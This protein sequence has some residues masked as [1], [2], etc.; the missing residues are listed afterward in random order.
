MSIRLTFLF[1]TCVL[2]LAG[3]AFSGDKDG[4][5]GGKAEPAQHKH[6]SSTAEICSF[7]KKAHTKLSAQYAEFESKTLDSHWTWSDDSVSQLGSALA[8]LLRR[9]AEDIQQS[10]SES[11][12]GPVA[13]QVKDLAEQDVHLAEKIE[14][15]T[16][17][18]SIETS[19]RLVDATV[20]S[21]K[22]ICAIH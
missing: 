5:T 4:A 18:G 14:G 8:P 15:R 21:V 11:A 19:E 16:F 13:A 10:V 20:K 12:T 6:P 1:A 7:F 22:S 17:Q 9:E 2:G 3:C